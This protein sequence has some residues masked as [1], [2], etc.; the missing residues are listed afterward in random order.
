M[1]EKF[2]VSHGYPLPFGVSKHTHGMNFSVFSK[3]ATAVCLCLFKPQ[4]ELPCVEIA[5]DP[6]KNKTGDVWHIFVESIPEDYCYGY[7]V[8][9][10]YDPLKGYYFDKRAILLDPFAKSVVSSNVW[11]SL[12]GNPKEHITRGVVYPVRAFDW[13][14]D[15]PPNIPLK[16]LIIYEM[17]VRSFTQDPSSKVA[18]AGTFLGMIEKIPYLKSLGVNAVELMPIH[19]FSE[20][21]NINK[22]PEGKSLYQ[23]WGYSTVNFFSP[24]N[25]FGTNPNTTIDEFKMLVKELHANGIEVILDVVYN[26]TSEGNQSGPMVSYKGLENP[27]YYLLGP[28][29]EYYNFSGCGNTFNC[30]NPAVQELIHESLRYWVTEMRVDGFR[31]DLASVLVRDHDGIPLANPPI[32]QRI[33]LDPVL[34]STK[35]IAEAW[36]AGGLYQVGSFPGYGRWA[37]WNGRYRDEVRRFLKGTDREL[38]NFATRLTGSEDLYGKGR[39]PYHSINFITAHDGFTLRDLVSYNQKHNEGNGENNRDGTNDNESWNCGA[40][41][42]T[43]DPAIIELRE[44]QMRNFHVALMVSQGVPMILMGDEYG[45]TRNGNNNSWCQDDRLNWFQWDTLEKNGAFFRFYQKMIAF[46]KAHPALCNK[47][48]LKDKD[49]TWHGKDYFKPDWNPKNR[50]IA[51]TLHDVENN[52]SLYVAFN[53][54]FEHISFRVP[55]GDAAIPWKIIVDTSKASPEDFVDE[56]KAAI[57]LLPNYI[58]PPHST[59]IMKRAS[60]SSAEPPDLGQL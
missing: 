53:A 17:H 11:G 41:G 59:L 23:Y 1:E 34:S 3:H 30:N 29:G 13:G 26:H 46:R 6:K 2:L 15:A 60:S 32:V 37:E 22:T 5:L 35:L 27:T 49:I 7:R 8:D 56:E 39:F 48:F 54:H 12:H 40:E 44:R 43:E 25:R 4:E 16:D 10:P 14:Q 18:H 51:F 52:Y 47:S 33:S 57:H 36:D 42:P 9:G 28:N 55:A 19:E 20:N 50:L 45:H 24:M 58:L 21:D 31:F 38:G